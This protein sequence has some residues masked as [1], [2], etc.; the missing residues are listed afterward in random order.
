MLLLQSLLVGIPQGVLYGLMG[1]GIALIFRT[2]SVM[3]FAHGHSGMIGTCVA[4]SAYALTKNLLIAILAGVLAGFILGILIE[5]GL[6][7]PIKHLSHGAMIIITLGLLM[8]FEG[9]SV[10]I[11]GAEYRTFPEIYTGTPL[12]MHLGE[13]VIVI[14][15]N[16]IV[17]TIIAAVLSVLLAIFL[18][19]TKLGIATRARAQDEVGS[20]VVGMN[21]NRIDALV[22]GVGIAL[23]VL[24]GALSAPKSYVNPNMMTNMLI[25]GLTACIL[26]GFGNP[27][28]AIAGGVLL[29][30]LEKAYLRDTSRQELR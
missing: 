14:T 21:T 4:F 15:S 13:G 26:G 23:A 24:V 20:K 17:I 9:L 28:G 25:F 29:G 1:F 12:I 2:T 30:M 27:F 11:W 22:W 19:Y 8:I 18:V 16:D 3:N 10:V 6:M 5:K 7:R